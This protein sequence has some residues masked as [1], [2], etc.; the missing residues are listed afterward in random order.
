[1]C[2]AAAR[3]TTKKADNATASNVTG[4]TRIRRGILR[5]VI[6]MVLLLP[7]ESSSYKIFLP[8]L[9]AFA[10]PA[11]KAITVSLFVVR[12]I[13]FIGMIADRPFVKPR[14]LRIICLPTPAVVCAGIKPVV[15]PKL[16]RIQTIVPIVVR[17][18][19]WGVRDGVV[20]SR[21]LVTLIA[22]IMTMATAISIAIPPAAPV[23]IPITIAV[24]SVATT[25]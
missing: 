10:I 8:I 5:L 3:S 13:P 21:H 15:V 11:Q 24:S 18:M 25:A 12:A 20:V 14:T 23:T 2:W 19:D 1:M 17:V 22:A 7:L 6:C 4:R 16:V 9:V